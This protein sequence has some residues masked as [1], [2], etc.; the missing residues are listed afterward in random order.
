M[1][2]GAGWRGREVAASTWK[3]SAPW[4][5]STGPALEV[6]PSTPW[7]SQLP[8][9]MIT[10]NSKCYSLIASSLVLLQP[11]KPARL[12]HGEHLL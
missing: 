7:E 9:E 4:C 8:G 11:A 10:D 12:Q 1:G 3:P 6:L 2:A 5:T